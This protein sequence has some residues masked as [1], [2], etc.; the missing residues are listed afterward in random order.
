MLCDWG[1]C[2]L[3]VHKTIANMKLSDSFQ[4][5][6]SMACGM[7]RETIRNVGRASFTHMQLF[8]IRMFENRTLTSYKFLVE[9][10]IV[11]CKVVRLKYLFKG[12]IELVDLTI[13]TDRLNQAK[14]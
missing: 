8:F 9:I 7:A 2:C 4:P 11:V 13:G 12:S 10:D 6:L 3:K 1:N 14:Y 5:S